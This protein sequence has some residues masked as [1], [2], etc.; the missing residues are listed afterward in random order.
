MRLKSAWSL[1]PILF[2]GPVIMM[3]A[4]SVSLVQLSVRLLNRMK[5]VECAWMPVDEFMRIWQSSIVVPSHARI[6]F[7]SLSTATHPLIRETMY[8]FGCLYEWSVCNIVKL[9]EIKRYG[10]KE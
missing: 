8:I 3:A 7:Q 1:K 5:H 4:R 10:L 6:P 2:A 9:L